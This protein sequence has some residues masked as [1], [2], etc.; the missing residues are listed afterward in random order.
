MH[1]A[2]Y[3]M[4]DPICLHLELSSS[5]RLRPTSCEWQRFEMQAKRIKLDLAARNVVKVQ[6]KK[7]GAVSS[8]L[9]IS[10]LAVCFVYLIRLL[11]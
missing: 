5:N 10:K 9:Q 2:L 6:Y 3:N 11:F 8:M 7:V 1:A 4:F